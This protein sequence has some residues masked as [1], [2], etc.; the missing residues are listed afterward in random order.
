MT[1]R[2]LAKT[3]I[4]AAVM[5]A[6]SITLAEGFSGTV[7]GPKG[8][9]AVYSG[10]CSAGEGSISC[11][12]ESVLT[13]PEGKTATRSVEKLRTREKVSTTVVTTGEGGRS[14]TTTRERLR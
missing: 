7:T 11:S 1:M 2:H 9:T 5:A 14:V 10:S 3:L 8:G 13:S 4:L 12:R 6:P